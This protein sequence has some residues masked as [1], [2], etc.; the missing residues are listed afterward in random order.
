MK[1]G[2]KNFLSKVYLIYMGVIFVITLLIYYLPIRFYLTTEK[3]KQTIFPVFVLWAKLFC[4]F[5]GLRVITKKKS[6]IK[7]DQV[8]FIA[9]HTSFLDIIFMYLL[10]PK[11]PFL[12]LG[13]SELLKIPL[14]KTF[15]KKLHIPVFREDRMKTGQSF[16]QASEALKNGWSIIIFPEGGIKE[17]LVPNLQP[18]KDGAFRLSALHQVPLVPISFLN[19]Y[20]LFADPS[21]KNAIARPGKSLVI[22]H[23]C[24]YINPNDENTINIKKQEAFEV[25]N[26]G[27]RN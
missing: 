7:E 10:F 3:K 17:K 25:I 15:F 2:F 27:L 13:K 9:N 22:I 14:V 12:F 18:F 4:L 26:Q 6:Q 8:I 11:H 20:Q 23:D 21:T 5:T 16:K 24:I 19:N 1:Q